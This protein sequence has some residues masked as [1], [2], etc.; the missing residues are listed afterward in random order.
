MSKLFDFN[1]FA[2]GTRF[3]AVLPSLDLELRDR[4]SQHLREEVKRIEL[5]LSYFNKESD[6]F[7]INTRTTHENILVNDEL[8]NILETCKQYNYLTGG[9]F[10]ITLRP[11]IHFWQQQHDDIIDH[12]EFMETK[13]MIGFQ[14]I[15]LN[16]ENRTIS[17]EN[18]KTKID[19][20]GFGKGYALEKVEK[21]LREYSV[22]N[23]FISFGES[24]VLALGK[25]P[26]GDCWKI[27]INNYLSPGDSIHSFDVING[28][29]S[30]SS[31]FSVSDSGQLIENINVMNPATCSPVKSFK[32]VSVKSS[33]AIQSEILSTS[34]LVMEKWKI[35]E[36]INQFLS[37][38]AVEI[39][40]NPE[41]PVISMYN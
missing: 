4:V 32:S 11:L 1:F 5:L 31:N 6:V 22:E 15:Q 3:N 38:S 27:G 24:S 40:Y 14:K 35:E 28:S 9:A 29:V 13:K 8:F 7:K 25:H 20:G 2:M 34:L 12:E 19:F 18:C 36:T 30:T 17:F 41:R 33:S 21:I 10:D 26:N 39:L 23:A 16:S 37:S